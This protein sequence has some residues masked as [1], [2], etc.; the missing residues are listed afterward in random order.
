M[1][2]ISVLTMGQSLKIQLKEEIIDGY[3]NIWEKVESKTEIDNLN[4]KE[5]MAP[6]MPRIKQRGKEKIKMK[7]YFEMGGELKHFTLNGLGLFFQ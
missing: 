1:E 3:R 7:G 6:C 2:N 5:I 4:Q